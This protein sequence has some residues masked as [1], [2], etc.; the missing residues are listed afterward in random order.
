[1]EA[2]QRRPPDREEVVLKAP[3]MLEAIKEDGDFFL[4]DNVDVERKLDVFDQ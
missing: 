4:E 2:Y 1:M 3:N